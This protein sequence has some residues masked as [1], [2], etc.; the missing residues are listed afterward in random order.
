MPKYTFTNPAASHV[1]GSTGPNSYFT[2]EA[3]RNANGVF[4]NSSPKSATGAIT[5][6]VN[7]PLSHIVRSDYILSVC[8]P[9]GVSSFRID[10]QLDRV[11]RIVG[12]YSFDITDETGF[13]GTLV[14]GEDIYGGVSLEDGDSGT[15]GPF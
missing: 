11:I 14:Y 6:L 12:Q 3:P 10:N 15:D 5:D 8:I 4:D 2:Y 7:I 1:S 9:S 13:Y